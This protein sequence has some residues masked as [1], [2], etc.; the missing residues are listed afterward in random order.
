M[1]ITNTS[2]NSF[3]PDWNIYNE[4]TAGFSK[5]KRYSNREVSALEGFEIKGRRVW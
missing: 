2:N 4:R 5:V 1:V 3:K